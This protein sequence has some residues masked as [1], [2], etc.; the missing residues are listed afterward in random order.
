MRAGV[1]DFRRKD[2]SRRELM[3][4]RFDWRTPLA[5]G[6]DTARIDQARELLETRFAVL[7]S[8]LEQGDYLCGD[9]SVADIGTFVMLNAGATLGCAPSKDYER[10]A[11][12]TDRMRGRP[13]VARESDEM[14]AFVGSALGGATA[15]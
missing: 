9:Y 13:P 3:P 15:P 7:E 6:G 2:S 14:L 11:A 4:T 8:E 1:L 5:V 12:W 10:L